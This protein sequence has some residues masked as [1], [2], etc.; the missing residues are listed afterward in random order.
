[1]Q[2][3][4]NTYSS[5]RGI[6]I[7]TDYILGRKTNLNKG[8]KKKKFSDYNGIK[9]EINKRKITGKFPNT[10]KLHSLWI[11]EVSREMKKMY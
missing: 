6:Y 2:Q 1:M 10:Y 5:V 7:N 8:L 3:Q 9:V 11:K 4:Q